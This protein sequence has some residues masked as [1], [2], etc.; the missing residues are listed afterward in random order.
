MFNIILVPPELPDCLILCR[1]EV[2]V[3]F[4]VDHG[5]FGKK[6]VSKTHSP[7]EQRSP[8]LLPRAN[9]RQIGHSLRNL[10][11]LYA[12]YCFIIRR[13]QFW[14]NFISEYEAVPQTTWAWPSNALD[15]YKPWKWP[16]APWELLWKK[17]TKHAQGV[18]SWLCCWVNEL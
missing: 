16:S 15:R 18:Y 14:K 13:Y 7:G 10:L 9:P 8:C 1:E 3:F 2:W 6:A 5:F 11:S 12:A 17:K 4:L